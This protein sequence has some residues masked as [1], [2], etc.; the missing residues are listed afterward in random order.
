MLKVVFLVLISLFLWTV[1]PNWR[2]ID[3]SSPVLY[4]SPSFDWNIEVSNVMQAEVDKFLEFVLSQVVF[5]TLSESH[6]YWRGDDFW[7]LLS[8]EPVLA[9][10]IVI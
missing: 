7:S 8:Y 1:S 9:K 6:S 4:K 5:D 3:E 10:E 2:N